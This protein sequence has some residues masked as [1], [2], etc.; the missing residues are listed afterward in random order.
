MSAP[1]LPAEVA[2]LLRDARDWN[3]YAARLNAKAIA[4]GVVDAATVEANRERSAAATAALIARHA[5][6]RGA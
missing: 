2:R 5:R 3:A 4:A 6:R 1:A